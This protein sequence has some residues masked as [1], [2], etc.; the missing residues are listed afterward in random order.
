[1]RNANPLFT[2]SRQGEATLIAG[3]ST[4]LGLCRSGGQPWPPWPARCAEGSRSAAQRSSIGPDRTLTAFASCQSGMIDWSKSKRR[5][6]PES[7]GG[8]TGERLVATLRSSGRL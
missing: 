1:V 6:E 3:R 2:I 8:L 5:G 4:A 7:E